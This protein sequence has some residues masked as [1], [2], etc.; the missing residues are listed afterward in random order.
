MSRIFPLLLRPTWR[1][2]LIGALCGLASWLIALHPFFQGLEEWCQDACF[3]YRGRRDSAARVILVG[4]D[5]ATLAELP[6]PLAFASPEL[7]EVVEFL[8]RQGAAAVGI[9]VLVP[10]DLDSFPG[11]AG[12]RLGLAAARSGKVVLPAV[13][14]GDG[15]LVPPLSA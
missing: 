2:A 8:D 6:K 1:G 7:A 9:D 10:E 12:E 11:L 15:R 4:I 14:D 5:D 13:V 3:S